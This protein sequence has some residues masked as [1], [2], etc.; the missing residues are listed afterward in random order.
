MTTTIVAT[1]RRCSSSHSDRSYSPQT[2]GSVTSRARSVRSITCRVFATRSSPSAPT[3]SMPAVSMNCTGPSGCSS[4]GF[5]TGSVVVPAWSETMETLCRTSA[6]S[7]LDLPTLRRPKR[8]MCVR[9]P[10]GGGAGC[11]T[12]FMIRTPA[13]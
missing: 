7:R 11:C 4:K 2:P 13:G 3:S 5:S 6:L 10:L 8:P 1:P 9:C 12:T